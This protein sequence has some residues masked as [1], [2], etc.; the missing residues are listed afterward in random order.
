MDAE[1]LNLKFLVRVT[2]EINMEL[3]S[4]EESYLSDQG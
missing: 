1:S 4:P 2:R 3:Q